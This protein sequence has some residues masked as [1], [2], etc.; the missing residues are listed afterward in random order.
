MNIL[1]LD[2][3]VGFNASNW[4]A[5][6]YIGRVR[7]RIRPE[8]L[9][10]IKL[11]VEILWMTQQKRPLF[12]LRS[13]IRAVQKTLCKAALTHLIKVTTNEELRLIAIWLRGLCG[14]YL[15]TEVLAKLSNADSEAVRL[16]V[17]GALQRMSG[18][19][20][21]ERMNA[22]DPSP[23]VRRRASSRVPREFHSRLRQYVDKSQPLPF[24]AKHTSRDREVYIATDLEFKQPKGPKSV[25]F[26]RSV[27]E[28]IRFLVRGRFDVG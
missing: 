4:R 27:L 6:F 26:I 23:R 11:A 18:W 8:G 3:V 15:G 1:N 2:E 14:G 17:A 10:A 9:V 25:E 22:S 21:L 13:D 5:T 20:V 28:R 7:Y 24:V 12:S 16:K 19:S